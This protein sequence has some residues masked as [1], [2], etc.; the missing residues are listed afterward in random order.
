M[1]LHEHLVQAVEADRR[2]T[3]LRARPSADNAEL[4]RVLLAWGDQGRGLRSSIDRLTARIRAVA[5]LHRL[6]PHDAEDVVQTTWLRLIEHAGHVREPRAVGGWLETTARRESLRVLRESGRTQPV[7][8][9]QLEDCLAAPS[10]VSRH[11]I[12]ESEASLNHAIDALPG[13][14]RELMRMLLAEPSPSY[15]EVATKLK[16]PIGSI[17][18]T[19]QR[20]LERLRRDP[21]LA[22]LA[23]DDD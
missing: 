3:A 4:E 2:T 8:P 21:Q 23:D 15:A 1:L 19:R 13:R 11:D 22:V 9:E 7:E 10:V 14:Q 20:A 18:P 5:R 12:A 16:M 6:R 17:G